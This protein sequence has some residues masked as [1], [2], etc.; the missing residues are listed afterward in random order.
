MTHEELLH[1]VAEMIAADDW[2]AR[3]TQNLYHTQS[4]EMQAVLRANKINISHVIVKEFLDWYMQG[5]VD[6]TLGDNN[7]KQYGLIP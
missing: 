5:C 2:N 3:N 6:G 7:A 1:I 4:T